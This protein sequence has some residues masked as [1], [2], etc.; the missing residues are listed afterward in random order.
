[1]SAMTGTRSPT[2]PWPSESQNHLQLESSSTPAAL[3]SLR[4]PHSSP[5]GQGISSHNAVS[6]RSGPNYFSISVESP[7]NARRSRESLPYAQP[8][9]SSPKAQL[10]SKNKAFEDYASLPKSGAGI[11]DERRESAVFKLSWNPSLQR[12]CP[13]PSRQD[14]P[15]LQQASTH[16]CT[17]STERCAELLESSFRD[18]MLLDVRPYA[19]FAKGTIKGSLNLCIP[20]TLLKR[21]SF[22]TQKLA[23]TFTNELDKRSF[24]RWRNCRYIVVFDAATSDMKDAG[25]L[26]NVLKKF[27]VEGWGGEGLILLGGFKVFASQFP[28]LIRGQQAPVSDS[29]A[30]KPSRMHIDLPSVAPVVGGCA[31]PE[32][33][34]AAIPFFGNIRQHMD[35]IG[36]VGQIPLQIPHNMSE[37]RRRLL[38]SWLRDVSEFTDKG[39]KVS[40]RFLGLEKKELERMKKALSYETSADTATIGGSSENFRVAGIEKGTKNRYNDIYPFEHSRV[41]LQ[42]VSPGGCD[43]VNANHMKAAYSGKSYIATQAPVPDTFNDFWRV[44]WEQDVR[45]VVSLTA[46]VERGQVKCHPYWESGTYGPCQVNNFSQK[47]IYLNSQD[48]QPT[49]ME[50]DKPDDPGNPYIIVRHFGFSKQLFHLLTKY[51]FRQLYGSQHHANRVTFDLGN[52]VLDARASTF[53]GFNHHQI[54]ALVAR[55]RGKVHL[56]HIGSGQ[57]RPIGQITIPCDQPGVVEVLKT[58]FDGDGGLYVLQRF[59]PAADN[60][61]TNAN[62]P[63]IRQAMRSYINGMIYLSR[64]SLGSSDEPVRICAFPDHANY[65]P[66]ALAAAHRGSFAISWQHI[67]DYSEHEVVLY[68]SSVETNS[69]MKAGVIGDRNSH[70]RLTRDRSLHEKGPVVGL[71]FNDR[72]SQLLYRHRAQTLYGSFQRIDTS[73]FPTRP[74]LYENSCPVQFT[75]SLTLLF[76]IGI[77][78][79]GTHET[80]VQDGFARCHWKY[81]SF[82]M[83]THREEDWTV[84]CLMRS[85]AVCRAS[86]CE[87]VLHLERGRR[88]PDWTIVA[89]LWGFQSSDTSLG[90]IVAASRLGTRIAAANWKTV[91]VWALEPNALIEQ[92]ATGFYPPSSWPKRSGVIELRPVI[93][94][95][96]AVCFQLYFGRDEN[97]LIAITDRGLMYYDLSPSGGGHRM[98]HQLSI[99]TPSQSG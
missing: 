28:T 63:F 54:L 24:A 3:F 75:D 49:D 97:E 98:A 36:G 64:H 10:L 4:D 22:D 60:M 18:I 19:H 45:L 72:C 8:Q 90:C 39:R 11:D 48:P 15:P 13:I 5:L 85:S 16:G 56:F 82:G 12:R 53:A 96:D 9:M 73:P 88:L 80:R 78:F 43:Y 95:L 35:L 29:S 68:T 31:L 40:E 52:E 61:D 51:A 2:S 93:L 6:E 70:P 99:E 87:H 17:I 83:A 59:N 41:K 58:A 94:S 34:H 55:G 66:L 47:F 57:I 1:M 46:E 65:E 76:C 33:S 74:T 71:A 81:L 77:P 20:T 38:P 67:H 42:N 62:H 7:G 32:S 14:V 50:L 69:S 84:A 91:Y 89:R 30:G 21:P 26:T 44:V 37:S 79:Y 86:N 25:P 92:N 23:N 27:T